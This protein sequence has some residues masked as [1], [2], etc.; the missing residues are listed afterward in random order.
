MNKHKE[1]NLDLKQAFPPMPD[2]C[3]Q[4]LMHVARSVKEEEPMKRTSLRAVLIAAAIIIL[5][6]AVA[7]A[8]NQLG[9]I[10]IMPQFNAALPESAHSVLNETKTKTFSV[11]PLEITLREL[12]ADGRVVIMT[13]QAN[14]PDGKPA[15]LVSDSGDI[16]DRLPEA[17]AKRLEV[18]AESSYLDAAAHKKLPLY[19]VSS[20]LEIDYALHNGEEMRAEHYGD[21]GA[22]LQV[23]MLQTK[24]ELIKDTLD[25]ILT[26]HVREIDP[27]TK[28]FTPGNDWRIDEKISVPVSHLIAEKTYLP[29]GEAV[30]DGYTVKSLKA[31]QTVAGI[32]LTT[33]AE[34][35]PEAKREEVHQTLYTWEYAAED[36]VPFPGGISMSGSLEDDAWPAVSLHQMIGLGELPQRMKLSGTDGVSRITLE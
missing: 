21:D 33:L 19:F 7:L 11:G 12:L 13:T 23:D 27:G 36:G 6:M 4:A 20:Y 5:T 10:D 26:L 22:L 8:A 3:Y 32:Y 35:G 18:P 16:T 24:A 34:A 31:E 14:A 2:D 15:V 29:K 1:M 25:A 17:L 30:L 9:L 28:E